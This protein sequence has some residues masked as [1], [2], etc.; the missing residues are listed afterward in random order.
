MVGPIAGG[1]ETALGD[2]LY[3]AGGYTTQLLDDLTLGFSTDA[4]AGIGSLFS[5]QSYDDINTRLRNKLMEFGD[6]T[7]TLFELDDGS[8][9]NT[10][11]AARTLGML[12]SMFIPGGQASTVGR[13]ANATLP[14]L[15]VLDIFRDDSEGGTEYLTEVV[16][17]RDK[18]TNER[19]IPLLEGI[20]AGIGSL[21]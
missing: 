20:R 7:P 6:A 11:D 12:G 14:G 18:L 3:N 19:A 8:K 1:R 2:A 4:L 13:V 9:V 21:F 16:P 5:D 10:M 15:T 17:D